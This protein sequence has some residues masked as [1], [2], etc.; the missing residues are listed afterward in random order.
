MQIF[1]AVLLGAA[2]FLV[3]AL[4]YI[5]AAPRLIRAP[6]I[7]IISTNSPIFWLAFV[8]SL[9]VGYVIAARGMWIIEGLLL[10]GVMFILGAAVYW[11]AYPHILNLPPPPP[12]VAVGINIPHLLP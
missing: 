8:A 9:A 6:G 10:G 5:I 3:C 7:G 12:G 2:L 1:K 4:I 11:I